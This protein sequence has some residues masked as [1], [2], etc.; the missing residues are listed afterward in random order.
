MNNVASCNI[1]LKKCQNLD[2][3]SDGNPHHLTISVTAH[4]SDDA[5]SA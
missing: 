4:I 1:R 5:S 3:L 2:I